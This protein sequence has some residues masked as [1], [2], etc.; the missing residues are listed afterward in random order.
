M[1]D[2]GFVIPS[3]ARNLTRRVILNEVKNLIEFLRYAQDK[4]W[5]SPSE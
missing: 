3:E 2:T 4:L 1:T 5:A